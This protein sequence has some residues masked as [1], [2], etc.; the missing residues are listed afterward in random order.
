MYNSVKIPIAKSPIIPYN[1][2]SIYNLL[3]IQQLP[4]PKR[5]VYKP[6]I[7]P[8]NYTGQTITF[9]LSLSQGYPN[10]KMS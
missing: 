2:N 1:Y 8:P 10:N 9:L 4:N 7:I 6:K 5:I 3:I